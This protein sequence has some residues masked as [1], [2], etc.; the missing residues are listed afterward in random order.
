MTG[1]VSDADPSPTDA[2]AAL[3]AVFWL[4][5]V[6]WGEDSPIRFAYHPIEFTLESCETPDRHA[7]ES[8][9]GG[10]GVFDYDNDRDLDI[11]FPN[12]ADVKTFA[13]S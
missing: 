3:V 10:V 8:M 5:T 12:G 13:L 1:M 9:A 2:V 7:P 4:G 6:A 11:F